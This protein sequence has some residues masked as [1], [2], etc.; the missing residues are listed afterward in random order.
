MLIRSLTCLRP[1]HDGMGV[2]RLISRL[3]A[4]RRTAVSSANAET[5]SA[6][7]ATAT[8]P[9]YANGSEMTRTV[10]PTVISTSDARMTRGLHNSLLFRNDGR[11]RGPIEK[12]S[13]KEPGLC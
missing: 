12:I 10:Q 9:P 6:L 7:H 5:G 3:R 2:A 11:I 8:I 4:N 1:N 13:E